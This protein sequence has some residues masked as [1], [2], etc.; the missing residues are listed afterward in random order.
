MLWHAELQ[1]LDKLTTD[2]RPQSIV[3]LRDLPVNDSGFDSN[4]VRRLAKYYEQFIV[5]GCSDGPIGAT[6][7]G[8]I[9]TLHILQV[10]VG[11]KP[12]SPRITD[13]EP[14]FGVLAIFSATF[15]D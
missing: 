1:P 6:G 4:G 7:T 8:K 2:E 14:R 3:M 5:F 12:G 13:P 10:T 9:L 15:E 11:G